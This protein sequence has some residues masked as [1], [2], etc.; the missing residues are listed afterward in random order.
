LAF[1]SVVSEQQKVTLEQAPIPMQYKQNQT[2]QSTTTN[3]K[4][5]RSNKLFIMHPGGSL[6]S[7]FKLFGTPFGNLFQRLINNKIIFITEMALFL[8][9]NF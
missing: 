7:T 2:K 1:V 6:D 8:G 3:E 4:Q 5:K 9:I